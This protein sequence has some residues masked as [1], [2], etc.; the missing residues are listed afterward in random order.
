M[1]SKQDESIFRRIESDVLDTYYKK[2]ECIH[3]PEDY[4]V[5]Y[6]LQC[7][8][9]ITRNIV[10]TE[11]R[12]T[13][14]DESINTFLHQLLLGADKAIRWALTTK[15]KKYILN[16]VDY[17]K[18]QAAAAELVQWGIDYVLL[19]HLH[20]AYSRGFIDCRLSVDKKEIEFLPLPVDTSL[21]AFSQSIAATENSRRHFEKIWTN[22]ILMA[23]YENW[24]KELSPLRPPIIPDWTWFRNSDSF[25]EILSWTRTSFLEILNDEVLLHNYTMG[26]LRVFYS[27]LYL[28]CDFI[29]VV[30]DRLDQVLGFEHAY[31][32]NPVLLLRTEMLKY[33]SVLTELDI[34]TIEK[35]V[36]VLSFDPL[37][38]D[39]NLMHKPFIQTSNG[40]L[41]FMPRHFCMIDPNHMFSYAI[42]HSEDKKLYNRLINNIEDTS[43]KAI[44]DFIKSNGCEV[45]SGRNFKSKHGVISPDIII[46]D[47]ALK[48]ALVVEYKHYLSPASV[49]YVIDRTKELKKGYEQVSKYVSY[50]SEN[51]EM[52]GGITTGEQNSWVIKGLI[53]CRFPVS[54]PLAPTADFPL[55]DLTKFKSICRRSFTPSEVYR[56]ANDSLA[57]DFEN[58]IKVE[59]IEI[60]VGEWTYFRSRF[61]VP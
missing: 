10:N 30:E 35:I 40:E 32:S 24:Y 14:S 46:C 13:R 51:P 59:K 9:D 50:L 22:R 1:L 41:M 52:L 2:F 19:E 4:A 55:V 34:K 20:I 15:S 29:T 33:L 7:L 39:K 16:P 36:A 31:G 42:K 18:F 23:D 54:V 3:F 43:V 28:L 12:E 37:N 5:P 6:I 11:F 47:S 53:L 44:A 45:I 58:Q 48:E 25:K 8:G 61:Y 26:D 17:P 38:K 56:H 57:P 27:S 49:T 21:I 60:R